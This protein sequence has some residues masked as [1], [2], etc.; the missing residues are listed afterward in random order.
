MKFSNAVFLDIDSMGPGLDFSALEP[1]A[2]HWEKYASTT[3]EETLNRVANA[4]LIITNKVVLDQSILSQCKNLQLICVTATGT[5]NID[6]NSAKQLGIAVTNVTGYGTASVVQHVFSLILA[7]TTRLNEHSQSSRNGI[8]HRSANFCVLDYPFNELAGKTMGIIGYG[9]L[10]KGVAKV[11]RA[12]GMNVIISQR[13][14][15]QTSPMIADRVPVDKLLADSDVISLHVPLADN[16]R[17]LISSDEFKL[18]KKS[19]ILIN[20]ARGGIVNE[21]ALVNA[22]ANGE[23]SGAGFDV[24]SQEPPRSDNPLLKYDKP[25]L[26]VTPHIAWGAIESRQRLLDY[27]VENIKS[28]IHGEKRNRVE[29]G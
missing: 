22:L 27:V 1:M 17:N 29:L 6:L 4:E 8:W 13:P 11:A 12:F 7:L 25:N 10:G 24:L 19:A 15:V 3:A 18:M 21:A 26:I 28:F 5:N 9:E 23:I 16:T 20:A 2:E 14:G